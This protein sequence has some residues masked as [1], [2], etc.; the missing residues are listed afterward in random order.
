MNRNSTLTEMGFWN[1]I[2]RH[3]LGWCKGMSLSVIFNE[4]IES[5]SEEMIANKV[6]MYT[7]TEHENIPIRIE[8]MLKKANFK[9]IKAEFSDE[10][11]IAGIAYLEKA[12]KEELTNQYIAVHHKCDMDQA[13]YLMALALSYFVLESNNDYFSRPITKEALTEIETTRVGRVARAMLMPQKSMLTLL[14]SP[15]VSKDDTEEKITK[16]SR[17]FLVP[18]DVAKLR[19]KEVG[20]LS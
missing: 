13:R 11:I 1:I 18:M 9:L 6:L 3:L 14:M 5:M 19:M 12:K 20:F 17:A 8:H 4:D 10:A 2:K 16:V 15:L 7:E